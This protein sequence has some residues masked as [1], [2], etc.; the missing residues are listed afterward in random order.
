MKER[1][2]IEKKRIL[3]EQFENGYRPPLAEITRLTYSLK[4]DYAK[5]LS[6]GYFVQSTSTTKTRRGH[7]THTV[8]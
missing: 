5:H 7:L 3:N 8:L 6:Y 1:V 2:R 4:K